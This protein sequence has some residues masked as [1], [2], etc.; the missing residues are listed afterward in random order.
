MSNNYYDRGN[1]FCYVYYSVLLKE[2]ALNPSGAD[3]KIFREN[4]NDLVDDLASSVAIILAAMTST[5]WGQVT[6]IYVIELGHH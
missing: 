5:H 3:A 2:E 6:Q 4:N 1:W